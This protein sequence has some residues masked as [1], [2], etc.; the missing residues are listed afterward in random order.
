MLARLQRF[1]TLSLLA[2]VLGWLLYFRGDSAWLALSG[3]L[4]MALAYSG[5][6]GLEFLLLRAVNKSD[7]AAD[8][9]AK[10]TALELL[11]AWLGETFTAPRVFFWQQPFRTQAIPDH[12]SPKTV[13]K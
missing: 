5:F 7:P 1:I 13:L 9:A 12:L 2:I 6:L 3:F 11:H 10:A 4:L 8:P